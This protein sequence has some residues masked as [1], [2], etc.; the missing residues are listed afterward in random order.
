VTLD[1][2]SS[3]DKDAA[4]HAAIATGTRI[5]AQFIDDT[6]ARLRQER[7]GAANSAAGHE[8]G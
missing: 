5:A 1:D 6:V 3:N 2:N 7:G 8:P 4:I